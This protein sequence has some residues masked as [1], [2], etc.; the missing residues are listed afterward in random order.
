MTPG[1]NCYILGYKGPNEV[2]QD[3]PDRA[4][5]LISM[6]K[7]LDPEGETM[8]HGILYKFAMLNSPEIS[9]LGKTLSKPILLKPMVLERGKPSLFHCEVSETED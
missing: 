3:V 1:E 7:F 5:N 4:R 8:T 6:V 9:H 2:L